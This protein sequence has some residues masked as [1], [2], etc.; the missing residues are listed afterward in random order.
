MEL[1]AW[2]CERIHLTVLKSVV[3]ETVRAPWCRCI[4]VHIV[5]LLTF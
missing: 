1:K 5:S 2:S 4:G 3:V